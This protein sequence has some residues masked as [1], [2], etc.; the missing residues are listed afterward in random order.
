MSRSCKI[1]TEDHR[2][3]LTLRSHSATPMMEQ[4]PVSGAV[5][6]LDVR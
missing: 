4:N 6:L 5:A 1:S 2:N 3:I